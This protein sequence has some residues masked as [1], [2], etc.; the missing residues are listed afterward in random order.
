MNKQNKEILTYLYSFIKKL[1]DSEFEIM[2]DSIVEGLM[3]IIEEKEK[4][5]IGS[6]EE[7]KDDCRA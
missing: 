2:L 1:P 6:K 4:V 7:F 3:K 5:E